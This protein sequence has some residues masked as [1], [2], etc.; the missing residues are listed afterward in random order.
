MTSYLLAILIIGVNFFVWGLIGAL[1]LVDEIVLRRRGAVHHRARQYGSL[2]ELKARWAVGD[3]PHVR[4]A[5]IAVLMAAHNEELVIGA[6][7]AGI[8]G[9]VPVE[10]IHV[11]SDASTDRTVALARTAGVQ[12]VE[13]VRNVGKAGA[14]TFAIEHFAL[15]TRYRAVMVLD[16]DTQLDREYFAHALPLFDDP[17]VA[18]VAGCAHTRWQRRL[19]LRANI[20]VAHRQR[21][22]VLTQLLMKYGQTWRGI[23]ATHIVPGFASIYRT[24][25][26]RHIDI[27]APGLVIEDFNMTFQVHAK[28]L[29]RVVFHP[30]ARAY[31]QDPSSYRDYVQQ[32][33]RWALGL[34]QT[35]RQHPPRRPVFAT[36]LALTLIELLTSSLIFLLLVP[37]VVILTIVALAPGATGLP[38]VGAILGEVS[39]HVDFKEIGLGIVLP[40]YLLTCAVAAYERRPSLLL[41]GLLFIPMKVTDAAVAVQAL[42]RA[43]LDR[44]TGRWVSPTRRPVPAAAEQE[45]A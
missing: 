23:S 33:R 6:S 31:T 16:A 2:E 25:A 19:G 26:M 41:S 28:R 43:W 4:V 12:V 32:T 45:V 36:S 38:L 17:R 37:I 42:P 22:Y 27:D 15:L 40:D 29:G 30:S 14:L 44:S 8:A 5:D 11:V 24:S 20:L 3:R 35:V 18:A 34:W 21:I 10:N 9:L 1:R 13:T 7:L 39:A